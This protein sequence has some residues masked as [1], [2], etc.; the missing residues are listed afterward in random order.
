M[1]KILLLLA[2]S[3]T[4]LFSLNAQSSVHHIDTI[5]GLYTDSETGTLWIDFTELE[6]ELNFINLSIQD[7]EVFSDDVSDLSSNELYE[8]NFSILKKG[9]YDLQLILSTGKVRQFHIELNENEMKILNT[10]T[11]S[12]SKI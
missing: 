8:I 10:S 1:K 4:G 2:I 11:Y 5:N 7:N 12:S 9:N 6:S 3:I